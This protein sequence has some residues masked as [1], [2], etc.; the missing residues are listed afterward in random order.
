M[1]SIVIGTRNRGHLLG[2]SLYCYANQTYKDFELIVIDDGS[3][4]NT[5][6]VCSK[7][8]DRLIYVKLKRTDNRWRDSSSYINMGIRMAKG[9][10]VIPTHPEVMIRHD[11]L[12]SISNNIKD[13]RYICV[14]PYYLTQNDQK[15][16]DNVNW[17][18]DI[19]NIRNIPWFY[20]QSSAEFRGDPAYTHL[21][22]E[23]TNT[24]NSWVFGGLSKKTWRDI[25]GLSESEVWGP[26]DISFLR[27]R[28]ILGI[29]NFT[30][31]DTYCI[32]QNHDDLN[33]P[34]DLNKA[35]TFTKF[36]QSKEDCIEHNI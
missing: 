7:F 25:G 27:R 22:I 21:A 23:K 19:L 32:H 29:E 11:V 20:D 17:H 30:L 26:V 3:T 4:D 14:K 2:R 1:L 18:E 10:F 31:P 35:I 16:I 9:D 13:W 15:A 34:R 24:W 28:T 36:P 33:T 12:Q 8:D 6:E 5:Q